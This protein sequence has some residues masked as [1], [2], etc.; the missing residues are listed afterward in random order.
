[1]SQERKGFNFYRSYYDVYS[2]LRTKDEKV[3]FIDALLNRQFTGIE[4]TKLKGMADF[5]YVSQ[6][7]SIDQQVK[8]WEDKTDSK[9]FT[10][11]EGGSDTPLPQE[12]GKG[13]E[14]E[15]GQGEEEKNPPPDLEEF[16]NYAIENKPLVDPEIVEL[17]YKSWKEN[18]WRDGKNNKVTNWKSKLLNTLPY[19]KEKE[20]RKGSG[21][22][23]DSVNTM[24]DIANSLQ[25]KNRMCK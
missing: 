6:K 13:E 16:L 21:Q 20:E 8:G 19:L 23:K 7:H 14:K 1:M 24:I 18:N 9:L 17:K 11:T 25:E 2:K 12:E 4:P 22:K 10:P 5:A 3:Q 15:K